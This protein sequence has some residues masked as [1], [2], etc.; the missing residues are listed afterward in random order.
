MGRKKH[1]LFPFCRQAVQKAL[2][3]PPPIM[4]GG[5]SEN[6][7]EN[8]GNGLPTTAATAIIE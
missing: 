2:I 5:G 3:R 8:Q 1:E 6:G 7:L 4:K